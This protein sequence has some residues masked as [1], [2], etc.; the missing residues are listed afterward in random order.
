MKILDRVDRRILDILQGNN[1]L[2]YAEL[3]GLAAVSPSSCRRR[4][5][6]LRR[7]GVIVADVSIV[8]P[9]ILGPRLKVVALV[10]LERDTPDGHQSFRRSM[11]ALPQVVQCQF[12]S[13]S[14]DYVVQLELISMAEYDELLDRHFTAMPIVKRVESMVV[15]KDV[16]N[17]TGGR[18]RF[19]DDR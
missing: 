13:G 1:Q 16:K 10:T 4:V 9:E 17:G 3:A 8:D 19:P 7:D 6:A 5:E 15:L 12:V 11:K 14:C 2:T 18:I